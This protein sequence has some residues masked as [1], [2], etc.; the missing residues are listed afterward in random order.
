[1]QYGTRAGEGAAGGEMNEKR[2]VRKALSRM[3]NNYCIINAV[4]A[5]K[6]KGNDGNI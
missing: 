4:Q 5:E 1:M 2:T 6:R 3:R